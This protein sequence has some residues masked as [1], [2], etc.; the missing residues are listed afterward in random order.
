M[1]ASVVQTLK[2]NERLSSRTIIERLFTG[3]QSRSMSLFPLRVVYTQIENNESNPDV[4]ILVSVSKRHFKRAV[5]RNRVKRQIRDSYRRNKGI[6]D[7]SLKGNESTPMAMAF[8][9]LADK[10]YSS[11]EIEKRMVSLLQ[12]ISEQ[13]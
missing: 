6:L 8:I 3:G 10:L 12:R 9:W 5:K 11:A 1:T 13:Q 2:K 4:Q 7:T